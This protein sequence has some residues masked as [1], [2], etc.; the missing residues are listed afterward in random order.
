MPPPPNALRRHYQPSSLPTRDLESVQTLLALAR[1][2]LSSSVQKAHSPAAAVSAL[3]GCEQACMLLTL[4]NLDP[5]GSGHLDA[6]EL[7]RYAEVGSQLVESNKNFHLNAGVV[8]ALVLSVAFGLA[9]EE[10]DVLLA[11]S[12]KTTWDHGAFVDILSFIGLQVAV[13]LSFVTMM[14]SSRL[15]TQL[16]FWMPNLES[17]LWFINESARLTS[18]LETC[19]NATL[20]ST[21]L[22]LSLETAVASIWWL[23]AVAFLPLLL[24]GAAFY[25]FESALSKRAVDHLGGELMKAVHSVRGISSHDGIAYGGSL[26]PLPPQLPPPSTSMATQQYERLQYEDPPYEYDSVQHQ[27]QQ[28]QHHQQQQHQQR[29]QQQQ[30]Q[31]QMRPLPPSRSPSRNPPPAWWPGPENWRECG[32]LDQSQ[33]PLAPPRGGYYPDAPRG[34]HRVTA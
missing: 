21:L 1:N 18:Q 32:R 34:D 7:E 15:Y 9:Y 6:A 13:A 26:P 22:A 2:R 8:S 31:Q 17:Q 19:K 33:Q 11:L 12:E 4:S 30:Q 24:A 23:D 28:Q 5:D 3:G 25:L 27:Q 20:F 10:N 14:A 29:Q 16:A